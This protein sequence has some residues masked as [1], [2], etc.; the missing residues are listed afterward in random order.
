MM[1]PFRK[2]D[3]ERENAV[4]IYERNRLLEANTALNGDLK[5]AE[6]QRDSAEALIELLKALRE[7]DLT[8][9]TVLKAKL[10][11]FCIKPRNDRGRFVSGRVG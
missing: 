4:L 9:I 3:L 11:R 10:G 8:E 6:W 1:W 2:S 7:R 5:H